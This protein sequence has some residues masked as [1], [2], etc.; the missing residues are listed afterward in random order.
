MKLNFVRVLTVLCAACAIAALSAPAM[1]SQCSAAAEAGD[2]A[3]TY[4]GTILT[5]EGWI[6]VAS[7]GKFQANPDGTFSGT[8]TRSIGGDAANETLT[9]TAVVSS[10]CTAVFNVQVFESGV[11]VRT[12]TLNIAYDDNNQSARGIFSSLVLSDGTIVPNVITTDA[13]RV[14][15]GK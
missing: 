5:T 9:G 14:D 4:T 12:A 8:Q 11:L 2:W 15:R 3:Y 1:A 13:R 7:V 10:D 6:A